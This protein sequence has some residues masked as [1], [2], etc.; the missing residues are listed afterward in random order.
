MPII[1]AKA[2]I[3]SIGISLTILGVYM[4]YIN[5]PINNTV[6]DGGDANTDWSA[7]ERRANRRNIL[8]RTGVYI[9]IGGSLIQLISNFLTS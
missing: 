7:V 5:S 6:I 8:L 2:F 3:N 1:D 4:V 9:I